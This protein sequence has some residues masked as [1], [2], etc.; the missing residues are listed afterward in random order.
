L[1]TTGTQHKR[2]RPYHPATNGKVERFNGTLAREWAY[3]REYRSE[4][5]GRGA[6]VEF[7]NFY[8]HE[9][10]HAALGHRPPASRVPLATYR[11]STGGIIVPTIPDRPQQLSFDDLTA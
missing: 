8:N 5:E 10:P 9:R 2:T 3:V 7:L 6:L 1:E 11:L 4:E